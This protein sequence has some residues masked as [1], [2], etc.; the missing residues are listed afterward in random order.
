MSSEQTK[1]VGL[2]A[3]LPKRLE[4][5][6]IVKGSNQSYLLRDKL[7][8]KTHDFEPWQFFVLEVLPGCEDFPKLASV[9]Q[10]RFGYPITRQQVD[11]FFATVGDRGLLDESAASH[12]L[13]A[14]FCTKTYVVE[15]GQAKVKSFRGAIQAAG[16]GAAGPVAEPAPAGFAGE[17]A[18]GETPTAADGDD[19]PAGMQD[20]VGFDPRATRKMWVLFDPRPVLRHL[21]PL[22]RPLR[23]S[24]YLLPLLAL[25]AIFLSSQ[26]AHLIREDLS[27]LHG[28]TTL[29]EHVVFSMFTINLTVTL[30]VAFVA[31]Y[32]RATVSAIGISVFLGFL[33]RFVPRVSHVQ[34]LTRR[35]RMWLQ[36][37]PLLVRVGLFSIGVLLWYNT[38]DSQGLLPKIGLAFGIICAIDLLL[39]SA[40]PL[41]K[42]SGYHLLAAFVNEPHLRG[43]SYKAFMNKVTGSVF[44]ESDNNLLSA[45]ALAAFAYSFVLI[46]IVM[47]LVGVY[48]QQ[49]QLGATSIIIAGALGIYLFRRTVNRFRKIAEAYERSVQFDRWRKRTLPKEVIEEAAEQHAGGTL[50]SYAKQALPLTLLLILFLPYPYQPGGRFVTFPSEKLMISTDIPGV[51]EQVYFDGGESVKK[52]AVIARL[53]HSDFRVQINVYTAKLA[54]QQAVIDD[55][56]ARPKPEQ[57][58]LAQRAVEVAQMKEAFSKAKVP[59]IERLYDDGAVSFEELDQARREYQVDASEVAQSLAALELAKVGSTPDE[60]AAAEA[61]LQALKE[62]RTALADKLERTVL[63]MPMDGNILTLHLKQRTNSYLEKGQPFASVENTSFVTAE[64][65]IPESDI[66]YVKLGTPVRVRPTAYN[67]TVFDG[68]VTTIDRNV[69]VQSFGNVVKVIATI[70][71]K[72][73]QLKTGMTGYAKVEGQSMPVWKAFSLAILR[74][75]NV[76][77]WSWIP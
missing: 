55:L 33:P 25:A 54:E 40:N 75:V 34:Q 36:G 69:T 70:Q 11:E 56:K 4:A 74:F 41:V 47:L 5:F 43:K 53:A 14:P 16:G 42:S 10:D 63:Y 62:E 73:G 22:V 26:Y 6:R 13:L 2:P 17:K 72:E 20:A 39:V 27:R 59:R 1:K 31:Y 7:L 52:G 9:F 37:A 64:I 19:L 21:T 57:V 32:Y 12:P 28:A 46:V 35:E 77:V 50:S 58:R 45:Y 67:D 68:T 38:R 23:F 51:V 29:I 61:K 24:I 44:K 30:T 48:L 71:N 15:E 65:E 60:I 18:T 3:Y 76:Q 49:I 8:G 66:Q